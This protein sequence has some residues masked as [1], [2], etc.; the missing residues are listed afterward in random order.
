MDNETAIL[1]PNAEKR[2]L[3]AARKVF[4]LKGYDGARMQEIADEAGI[5]KALVHYYYR[6]KEKLFAEIFR[7]AFSTIL[8]AM[9]HVFLGEGNIGQKIELFV[10]KYLTVIL[11]NPFIPLFV[12]SEMHRNPDTFFNELVHPDLKIRVQGIL[13]LFE[14]AVEN[15]EIANIQPR[16]LMINTMALCV[17]PFIARPML[18]RMLDIP[19]TEYDEILVERKKVVSEFILNA[20]TPKI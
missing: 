20:I 6:N 9:A 5:N 4:T 3:E 14:K 11:Q 8:P 13:T 17:F 10:E 16:H 1:E 15:G 7:E 2:I 18:Q 12:L 19:D